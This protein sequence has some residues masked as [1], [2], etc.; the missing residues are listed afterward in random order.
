MSPAAFEDL[1]RHNFRLVLCHACRFAPM[2]ADGIDELADDCDWTTL[3]ANERLPWTPDFV[4]RHV[5]RWVPHELLRNPGIVWTEDLVTRYGRRVDWFYLS[6]NPNLPVNAELLKRNAKRLNWESLA[7]FNRQLT[8]ELRK[9]FERQ[10]QVGPRPERGTSTLADV[11]EENAASPL[12]PARSLTSLTPDEAVEHHA[13]INWYNL[14]HRIDFTPEWL[15]KAAAF[16][17]FAEPVESFYRRFIEPHLMPDFETFL[18]DVRRRRALYY[19]V[20]GARR[21]D[22]GLVPALDFASGALAGPDPV[23]GELSPYKEGPLRFYDVHRVDQVHAPH[24]LLIERRLKPLF[25][26]HDLGQHVF[27]ELSVSSG[28]KLPDWVLLEVKNDVLDHIAWSGATFFRY[29]GRGVQGLHWRAHQEL[30]AVSGTV[31]WQRRRA[32]LGHGDFDRRSLLP[33]PLVTNGAPDLLCLEGEL[34][35]SARLLHALR[36]ATNAPLEVETTLGFHLIGPSRQP[37]VEADVPR[38][39]ALSDPRNAEYLFFEHKKQRLD[40]AQRALPDGYRPPR[41]ALGDAERRLS[42]VF[43]SGFQAFHRE[44]RRKRLDGFSILNA[45]DFHEVRG[46][47]TTY[48]E[49]YGAVAIGS[50]GCGDC[51][52][53]LLK[54]DSDHEL[55]KQLYRFNHES[56]TLEPFGMCLD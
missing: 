54:R 21:D 14:T 40:S 16:F 17:E 52:G 36:S 10:L 28:K 55:G 6:Q 32:E 41:N 46:Y 37:A 13:A 56:G 35:M 38:V 43:P 3:S 11:L 53:L 22:W 30:G 25:L 33:S 9:Q 24:C 45:C 48:P 7:R 50:D 47:E 15:E 27:R 34:S 26:A 8:P 2:S 1:T 51:L 12:D 4:L 49:T 44:H 23:R 31:E 20:A 39:E 18:R 19:F 42:V 29:V 5:D